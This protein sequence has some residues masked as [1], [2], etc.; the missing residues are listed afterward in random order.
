MIL[1]RG[2]KGHDHA[3][4]INEQVIGC[5]DLLSTVLYTNNTGYAFSDYYEQYFVK[6][7]SE[8]KKI[9]T[10]ESE[11]YRAIQMA[12]DDILPYIYLTY[13]HILNENSEDW[14]EKS[15][16]DDCEFF[17][18]IPRLDTLTNQL[19][20]VNYFG[21]ELIY[22]DSIKD[23]PEPQQKFICWGLMKYIDSSSTLAA[24]LTSCLAVAYNTLIYPLFHRVRD[25]YYN[26]FE[27]EFRIVKILPA[28]IDL[29]GNLYYP[30]PREFGV[31]LD[32]I[33][34][35]GRKVTYGT[36]MKTIDQNNILLFANSC[37]VKQQHTTILDAYLAGKDIRFESQFEN[38]SIKKMSSGFGYIGNKKQCLDFIKKA[39]ESYYYNNNKGRQIMRGRYITPEQP[40]YKA[41]FPLPWKY[42][43]YSDGNQY[44]RGN[45]LPSPI[46]PKG[47]HRR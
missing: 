12:L 33:R 1:I 10:K 6:A 5:K 46:M 7:F 19:I 41:H 35:L 30:K 21:R 24:R 16:D 4:N 28:K 40:Y 45:P 44:K 14:L 25:D 23:S 38:I 43:D 47:I 2:V 17:Y 37:L 20:G 31:T 8:I 15:F 27:H 3:L 29:E 39:R 13:F 34:Y 11:L 36:K 9:S 18:F 32:G 22:V 42:I 26:D